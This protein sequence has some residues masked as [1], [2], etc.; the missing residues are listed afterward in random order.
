MRG[1]RVT[2]G[3]AAVLCLLGWCDLRLCGFFLLALT[4]HEL[5]HLA[6]LGLFRRPVR[7]LTLGAGGARIE[8]GDLTRRQEALSAAAGPAVN[9]LTAALT[10]RLWPVFSLVSLGLA[11]VNLLPLYPLDGGRILR[12]ALLSRVPPDRAGRILRLCVWITCSALM[13]G[14]CW[15]TARRQAGIWPI[16]AALVLLCRAG[17]A[18]SDIN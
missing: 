4:L 10:L 1:I 17:S 18:A 11:A 15:L 12:A 16:F 7:G 13:V 5:G 14:A 9:L 6:V 2:P 8:T 3:F